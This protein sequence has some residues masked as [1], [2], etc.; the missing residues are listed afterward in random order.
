MVKKTSEYKR[1]YNVGYDEGYSD[2]YEQGQEDG[3]NRAVYYNQKLNMKKGKNDADKGKVS[4]DLEE[5]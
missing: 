4:R 1:G 3:Y 2:G 5:K